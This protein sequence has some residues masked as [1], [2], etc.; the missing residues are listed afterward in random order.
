M[1]TG[2]VATLGNTIIDLNTTL[3]PGTPDGPRPDL[4]G[5]ITS[6]GHNLIGDLNGCKS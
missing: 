2:G 4:A 6:L 1:E 3:D 5:R